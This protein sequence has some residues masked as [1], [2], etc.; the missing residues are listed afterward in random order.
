MLNPRPFCPL[1]LVKFT[2]DI[3]KVA[4]LLPP[5]GN[6]QNLL[7]FSDSS[8]S[9]SSSSS[10]TYEWKK[11]KKSKLHI[12]TSLMGNTIFDCIDI[13][14]VVRAPQFH[15]LA[16]YYWTPFSS[17]WKSPGVGDELLDR[18]HFMIQTDWSSRQYTTIWRYKGI[19]GQL[20]CHFSIFKNGRMKKKR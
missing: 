8:S 19:M 14:A 9:P 11:Q 15:R 10:V 2:V 13:R 17:M 7:P 4:F 18:T 3:V 12:T 5:R 16:C 6:V 20:A 1:P